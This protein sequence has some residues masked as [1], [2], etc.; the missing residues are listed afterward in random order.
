MS[1]YEIQFVNMIFLAALVIVG[2]VTYIYERRI[3]GLKREIRRLK[4][5]SEGVNRA[6]IN[7]NKAKIN[8]ENGPKTINKAKINSENR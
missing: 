8:S 6:K 1:G 2:T 7:I 3:E 5:L 4:R